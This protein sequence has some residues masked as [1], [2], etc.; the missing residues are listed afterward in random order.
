[1]PIEN[2]G[3]QAA[4]MAHL[5]VAIRILEQAGPLLG[6]G[7]DAGR[8]VFMVLPK[9]AKHVPPGSVPTGVEN[10]VLQNL[11][12]KN[13]QN[14]MNVASMRG[15]APPGQPPQSAASPR[16]PPPAGPMSAAA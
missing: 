4:G 1:M 8:E 12:M 13:R 10:Q 5:A 11:M 6:V 2:R 3:Q 15:A 14:A 16:P 7:S 9:L